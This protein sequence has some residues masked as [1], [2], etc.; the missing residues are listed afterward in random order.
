VRKWYQNS[1]RESRSKKIWLR[2]FS[3]R[4]S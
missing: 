4:G 1:D 3:Q 2:C